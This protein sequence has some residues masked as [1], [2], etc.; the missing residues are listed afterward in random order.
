MK[1][2][3]ILTA[4]L[5]TAAAAALLGCS[6]R[7]YLYPFYEFHLD[8]DLD[9][10][11]AED[12]EV[13]VD[14]ESE[15]DTES[16]PCPNDTVDTDGRCIRYVDWE[17]ETTFCGNGWS[18]AFTNLQDGIDAAYAAAQELGS[19]EVWV[20][21]GRYRSFHDNPMDSFLLRANVQV[22][23]GFAGVEVDRDERDVEAR[24]TILDGRS[25]TGTQG[26]YHVVM[27]ADHG[28]LDG[29]TIT[30]GVANGDTPHDR[31]GGIY[32]NSAHTEIRN[33]TFVGNSAAQGGAAFLYDSEPVVD[34]CVFE[35]N[36]ADLGGAVYVLN[37]TAALIDDVIVGNAAGSL[38]GGIYFEAVIGNCEPSL[39]Q[40]SIRGNHAGLDGGGVYVDSC[41]PSFANSKLEDNGA[42]RDG[43][44]LFGHHGS[45]RLAGSVVS[46]NRAFRDGGG[47][48]SFASAIDLS[49]VQVTRNAA[50]GD[51]GGLRISWSD[52]VV[53]SSLVS[54]NTAAGDGGGFY[55]NEDAPVIVDSLVTG[56]RA[57][58]GGGAFDGERAES[59]FLNAVFHGNDA[60]GAGDALY[61]AAFSDVDVYNT[62]AFGNGEL[63]IFDDKLAETE[64]LF[65]DVRGGYAGT[66]NIDADPLFS[67]P[68][69][70]DDS[71][72]PDDAAD[73]FWLNGDYHLLPG[74]P[75][76]DRVSPDADADGADWED[77]ED[78]GLP[79][80]AS[81]IG[82]YD[83]QM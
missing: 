3:A 20:A 64:V 25:E 78:A 23:G 2:T 57:A 41:S 17:S 11:T 26:S 73:D 52:S 43:G 51:G 19:C 83:C 50:G 66:T 59:T 7:D 38:G 5:S 29:F 1:P 68:G 69:S 67:S 30:G 56:N 31:G 35:G 4:L 32:S 40:V 60:S 21:E 16:D 80:T 24:E 36:S 28:V 34:H 63:E 8:T 42:G 47:A 22:Y 77:V 49:S 61:N 74:S 46:R 72:T 82:A 33:C 54:A 15:T 18:G 81:D 70:W 37:G 75:C 53:S 48:A 12:T 39:A 76:V 13:L 9:T 6:D 10:E 14:T 27:G 79:D 44:G 55:V 62:I 71:G 45:V 65:C 58:R